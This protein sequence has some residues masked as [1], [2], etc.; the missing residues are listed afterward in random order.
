MTFGAIIHND[1]GTV[2][3]DDLF[4]SYTIVET[5]TITLS[6]SNNQ[7]SSGGNEITFAD[8]YAEPPL[9]FMNLS[10]GFVGFSGYK[11]SGSDYTGIKLV[12]ANG[13]SGGTVSF[14]ADYTIA[15][16]TRL[17]AIPGGATAMGMQVFDESGLAVFDARVPPITPEYVGLTSKTLSSTPA[18]FSFSGD[19]DPQFLMNSF[20]GR[21]NFYVAPSG[22][23]NYEMAYMA[24]RT[25]AG[26]LSHGP[27]VFF[28]HAGANSSWWGIS[29]DD[30]PIVTI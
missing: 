25:A 11:K 4:A 14:D 20:T 24:K 9:L 16:P 23:T 7:P 22:G 17:V 27:C 28:I 30:L 8:A 18:V 6:W 1:F 26:Q 12:A 19:S 2:Q 5:G 3:I 13:V 10:G 15:L 29:T 21:G